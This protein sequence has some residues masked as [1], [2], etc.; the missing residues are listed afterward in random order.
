MYKG[1]WKNN[2][3]DGNG[4]LTYKNGSEFVGKFRG[5]IF[6]IPES[7]FSNCFVRFSISFIVRRF[8]PSGGSH[9]VER[10]Q[11]SGKISGL[12]FFD[13]RK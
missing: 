12:S 7:N 1:E 8:S 6:S 11:I 13:P 4:T 9:R 10:V 5:Y 2:W 3:K